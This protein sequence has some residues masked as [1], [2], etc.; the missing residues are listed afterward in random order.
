VPVQLSRRSRRLFQP[1]QWAPRSQSD[2]GRRRLVRRP[3]TSIRWAS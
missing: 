3:C 2:S 1:D